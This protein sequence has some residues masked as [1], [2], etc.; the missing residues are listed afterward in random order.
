MFLA[1]AQDPIFIFPTDEGIWLRWQGFRNPALEGY[2]VYRRESTQS[3]WTLL[4]PVPLSFAKSETEAFTKTGKGANILYRLLGKNNGGITAKEIA[5][6][7]QSPSGNLFESMCVANPETG[8]LLGEL[9][10][11]S[12]AVKGIS[13]CISKS[14]LLLKEIL[15]NGLPCP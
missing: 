11:D 5:D 13:I 6:I 7:S 9:Y 1:K 4:T 10:L 14:G 3:D 2:E 8:L 12:T 15:K